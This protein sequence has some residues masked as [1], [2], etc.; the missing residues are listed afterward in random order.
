[1][2]QSVQD[3][4]GH[5]ARALPGDPEESRERKHAGSGQVHSAAYLEGERAPDRG[6]KILLVQELR[7]RV[8]TEECGRIRGIEV[9]RDPAI[10]RRPDDPA[11]PRN[12]MPSLS[13]QRRVRTASNHR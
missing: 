2:G 5:C 11:G 10:D 9:P 1:M 4:M 8:K 13:L 3:R 12:Q 6:E 7:E